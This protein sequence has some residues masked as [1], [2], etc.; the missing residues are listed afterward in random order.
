MQRVFFV[1]LNTLLKALGGRSGGERSQFQAAQQK[2]TSRYHNPALFMVSGLELHR[3]HTTS[4]KPTR[5]L[6]NV[7]LNPL[8]EFVLATSGR[9][10]YALVPPRLA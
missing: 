7:V 8:V 2:T 4:R 1:I 3:R 9:T 6:L 10:L 5:N